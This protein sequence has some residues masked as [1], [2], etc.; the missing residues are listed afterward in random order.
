MI[1]EF[2]PPNRHL[3]L[4]SSSPISKARIQLRKKESDYLSKEEYGTKVCNKKPSS[5]KNHC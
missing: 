3:K 2:S 4:Q 5:V 1:E